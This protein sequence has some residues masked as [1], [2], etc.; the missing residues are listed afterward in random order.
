MNMEPSQL[1]FPLTERYNRYSR[2]LREHF[3]SRIG[4][5]CVDA[6]FTC[7]TRDGRLGRGGCLY[8]DNASFA[9]KVGANRLTV[10]EQVAQ[11]LSSQ[12]DSTRRYLVYFQPYTNTYAPV[13]QL[14]IIYESVL[15]FEPVVGIIIGT[16]PDCLAPEVLDLLSELSHRTFV[17][18][19]IGLESVYNKSLKWA[20]RGHTFEQTCQALEAAHQY[21][22]HIAGHLILGFPTEN[23][24]E[25]VASTAILN[26]LPLGALKIH[27][28]HVVRGS[29]LEPYFASH[30]F[31]LFT[32]AEWV[33]LVCDFLEH[34]RPDIVIQRL[35]GEAQGGT[36]IAPHWEVPKSVVLQKI[37]KELEK[38]ASYQ[39]KYYQP[40]KEGEN[41][42]AH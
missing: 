5:I 39:G 3:G 19:E 41:V 37:V 17:S 38:R 34:L 23:Y 35:V 29:R 1:P 40:N 22:L 26:N 42:Y 36:L 4:R 12:K 33:N 2:F 27:H 7:P 30:P 14:R 6:G 15:P 11:F 20:E 24:N 31:P 32:V 16:R 25:A 10:Q 13:G 21:N 28:L 9:P 8:C 18:L